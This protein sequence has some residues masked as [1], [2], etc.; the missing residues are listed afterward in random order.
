MER[1]WELGGGGVNNDA[2]NA[3]GLEQ[4]IKFITFCFKSRAQESSMEDFALIVSVV[5][6]NI[7]R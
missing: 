7:A 3:L 5:E 1:K 2:Q 4:A 6:G